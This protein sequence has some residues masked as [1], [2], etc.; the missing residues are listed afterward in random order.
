MAF[1]MSAERRI[2]WSNCPMGKTG[3]VLVPGY[4]LQTPL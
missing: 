3:M 4:Y 1:D 2:P